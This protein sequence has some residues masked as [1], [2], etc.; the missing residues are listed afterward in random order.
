[1]KNVQRVLLGKYEVET[2]YFS[3]Y[4]DDYSKLDKVKIVSIDMSICRP[5]FS[6]MSFVQTTPK[7]FVCNFLARSTPLPTGTAT[8]L[9]SRF[10]LFVLSLAT[11]QRTLSYR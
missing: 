11:Y 5:F 4:P 8:C 6:W 3:P 10:W 1:M 2:W 9:C 7:F